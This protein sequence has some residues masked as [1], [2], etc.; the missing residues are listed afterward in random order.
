MLAA[1][2]KMINKNLLSEVL[3]MLGFF[4]A[5]DTFIYSTKGDTFGLLMV[6]IFFECFVMALLVLC[7]V[8]DKWDRRC[9]ER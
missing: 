6:M 7:V 3:V 5:L 9:K 2:N 4:V 8:V 1:R